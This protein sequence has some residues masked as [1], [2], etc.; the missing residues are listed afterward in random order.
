MDEKA[1]PADIWLGSEGVCVP[2]WRDAQPHMSCGISLE[3]K[4]GWGSIYGYLTCFSCIRKDC[5]THYWM[6][7]LLLGWALE[8]IGIVAIVPTS[9]LCNSFRA[10][11]PGLSGQAGW[12]FSVFN[13]PSLGAKS[14][15]WQIHC[16]RDSHVPILRAWCLTVVIYLVWFSSQNT[17]SGFE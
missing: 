10:W 14:D 7:D 15:K 1:N 12:N 11:T 9:L 8:I 16:H 5:P 17:G 6:W 2:F 4:V 3:L 13:L